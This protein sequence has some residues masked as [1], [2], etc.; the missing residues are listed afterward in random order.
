MSRIG[1]AISCGL[2]CTCL[3][4]DAHAQVLAPDPSRQVVAA[5]VTPPAAAPATDS[6]ALPSKVASR[7]SHPVQLQ[8]ADGSIHATLSAPADVIEVGQ[9]LSFMLQVSTDDESK[10]TMPEMAKTIRSFDISDI[11]RDFTRTDATRT[12]TMTFNASTYESGQ[13]EFPA[14]ELKWTD[15]QNGTHSIEAGPVPLEVV[16]LIGADFD[17]KKYQDIKNAVDIDIGGSWWW[18]AAAAAVVVAGFV[19]WAL[20]IRQKASAATRL[21]PHEVA[22]LELDRLER[23][24]LIE[25]GELHEFWVRLSGTVRQY[26][27]SRFEI[28]ATEQTTKEFLAVARNHPL[29][30]AEHRHLLT[31]FLRAA[32]M[33]KFAA[34]RPASEDCIAGLDAA[35]GFVRDTAQIVVLEREETMVHS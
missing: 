8:F 26:V 34:H 1:W 25:R 9:V 12:W 24:G 23:D 13:L 6:I 3:A 18:I 10:V 16:S 11:R 5:T 33:V 17:E 30:G 32:D 35:R 7:A 29:I 4:I 20:R 14:L 28:A 2:T 19:V 27:E 21:S 15:M 22:Q 31:D